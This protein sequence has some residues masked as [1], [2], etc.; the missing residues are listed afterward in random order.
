MLHL[1][2]LH[3]TRGTASVPF[4]GFGDYTIVFPAG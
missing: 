3:K 4:W 1:V 2:H